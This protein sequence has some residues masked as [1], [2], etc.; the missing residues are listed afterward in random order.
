M[1]LATHPISGH[2]LEIRQS[3][4]RLKGFDTA[5]SSRLSPDNRKVLDN[6]REPRDAK[7]NAAFP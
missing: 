3:S 7:R 1:R 6:S 2:S 5:D 4:G